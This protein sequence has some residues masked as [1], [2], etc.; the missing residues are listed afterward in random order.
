MDA[1]RTINWRQIQEE[2]GYFEELYIDHKGYINFM[3]L[4]VDK[5]HFGIV[6]T[7]EIKEHDFTFDNKEIVHGTFKTLEE[8]KSSE[9]YNRLENWSKVLIDNIHIIL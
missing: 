1:F 4:D 3:E 6:F 9:I 7:A 8:I 2:L 5:V